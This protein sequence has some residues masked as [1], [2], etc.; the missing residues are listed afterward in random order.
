ME[1]CST[2][3]V[4]QMKALDHQTVCTLHLVEI[5]KNDF[6]DM[7]AIG[8]QGKV[9]NS[10]LG[11]SR[12]AYQLQKQLFNTLNKHLAIFNRYGFILHILLYHSN[13]RNTLNIMIYVCFMLF[14]IHFIKKICKI[15]I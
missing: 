11:N 10:C 9:C 6:H 5:K 8:D 7:R 13:V 4:L 15:F 3:V 2:P 1:V 12:K 14:E